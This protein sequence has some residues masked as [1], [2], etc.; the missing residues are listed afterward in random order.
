MYLNLYEAYVSKGEFEEAAK[1]LDLSCTMAT[2]MDYFHG[3]RYCKQFRSDL[4]QMQ[5][6]HAEALVAYKD[7]HKLWQAQTGQ[8]KA[9][10]I[11][12]LRTR[13]RLQEKDLKIKELDE[14]RLRTEQA[15]QKQ[16]DRLM[17][18]LGAAI[19]FI[20]VT[21]F[22]LRDRLRT[23]MAEQQKTTAEFKLQALQSQMNPH[24]TFNAINGIQNFILKS[25]KLEA[26]N[27]LG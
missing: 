26:Y 8:E 3:L 24:F 13:I 21:Y 14:A 2:E 1:Y 20:L 10:S 11:Q 25:N 19:F 18:A 17:L 15:H 6:K 9:R 16:M 22:L 27:Y 7:Y 23:K 4:L 12:S 5:G